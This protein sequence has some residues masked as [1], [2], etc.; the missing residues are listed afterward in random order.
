MGVGVGP[1]VVVLLLISL[2]PY[3]EIVPPITTSPFW[4]KTT[5]LRVMKTAPP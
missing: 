3:D 1:S 4:L 5:E 2:S